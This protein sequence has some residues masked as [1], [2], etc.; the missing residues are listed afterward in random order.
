M[1]KSL[2][3]EFDAPINIA[4]ENTYLPADNLSKGNGNHSATL[5]H[6]RGIT[7]STG[8]LLS[9]QLLECA[10]DESGLGTLEDIKAPSSSD[11]NWMMYSNYY[12]GCVAKGGV[13]WRLDKT[14]EIANI[15]LFGFYCAGC[16]KR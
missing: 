16:K 8:S 15:W 7:N 9:Q 12:N 4:K 11:L 6:L 10:K 2:I 1:Y 13:A 5:C 3:M 14:R